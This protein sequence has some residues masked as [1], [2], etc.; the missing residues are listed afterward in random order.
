MATAAERLLASRMSS[1][2]VGSG[3]I[4]SATTTTT[5]IAR[6]A[7]APPRL[8]RGRDDRRLR[9]EA[10]VIAIGSARRAEHGDDARVQMHRRAVAERPDFERRKHAGEGHVREALA[11]DARV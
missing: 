1:S 8:D 11:H 4:M 7:S 9:A 2:Q 6:A 10:G 3:T 5:R